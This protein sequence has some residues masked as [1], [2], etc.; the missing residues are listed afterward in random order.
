MLPLLRWVLRE[1]TDRPMDLRFI[2]RSLLQT[3]ARTLA[4]K[5][6]VAVRFGPWDLLFIHRDS[7]GQPVEW[8]SA[9]IGVAAGPQTYVPVIPVRMTEA[10]LLHS[11]PAIRAAAGRPSGAEPLGLPPVRR[12]EALPDPKEMLREALVAAHGATGWRARQFDPAAAIHRVADLIE[13]W[14]PLR[15]LPAFRRLETDTRVALTRLG[16]SVRFPAN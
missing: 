13:D 1:T 10:W 16:V 2:D 15:E 5:V 8:R 9:E 3:R 7:D 11:E 14:R 4:E 12:L 6:E